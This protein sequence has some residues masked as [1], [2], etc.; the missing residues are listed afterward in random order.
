MKYSMFV[1][2]WQPWHKGHQWLIDQRLKEGKN[3]LI[4][5]QDVIPDHQNKWPDSAIDWD[6]HVQVIRT[7]AEYRPEYMRNYLESFFDLS[8][9]VQSRF[10]S[11]SGGNIQIN[12]IIPDSYP[13]VG[14][15]Y[16]DIPISGL[17]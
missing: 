17:V 4:C 14:E 10:Y 9:L 6:Y 1:G 8:N 15:Y 12:T 11:T 2:R 3:I 5:I 7:F 13:W 16:E